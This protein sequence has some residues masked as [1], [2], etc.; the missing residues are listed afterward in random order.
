MH[1]P[2]LWRRMLHPSRVGS[3]PSLQVLQGAR[4]VRRLLHRGRPAGHTWPRP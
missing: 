1:P 3:R 2:L 4:Q